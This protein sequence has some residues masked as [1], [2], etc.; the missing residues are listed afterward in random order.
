[1]SPIAGAKP[2][3]QPASAPASSRPV[4]P[5]AN[6]KWQAECGSCHLAYPPALLPERSWR[7]LMG[8]LDHHFGSS[9]ALDPPT[10]QE[11]TGFLV[12]YSADRRNTR[13]ARSSP[14]AATP[15]RITETSWFKREHDEVGASVW[16]RPKVGG[17]S[18]CM[19]CHRAADRGDFSEHRI[20]IPR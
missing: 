10:Q 5:A 20:S 15:L 18:N 9:A 3:G 6:A 17:A 13:L 19:A 7:K 2:R 8:D 1:M 14:A 11:I 12:S 16:K 4:A